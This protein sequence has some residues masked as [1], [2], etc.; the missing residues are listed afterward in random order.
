MVDAYILWR[1]SCGIGL[2]CDVNF[3]VMFT[4]YSCVL[5]GK[6]RFLAGEIDM[7]GREVPEGKV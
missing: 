4:C 7:M 6:K 1:L 2:V 3:V 5:V